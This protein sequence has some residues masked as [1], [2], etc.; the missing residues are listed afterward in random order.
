MCLRSLNRL[1][2]TTGICVKI[3]RKTDKPD[4]F[5]NQWAMFSKDGSGGAGGAGAG[6]RRSVKK[7]NRSGVVYKIDR[8]YRVKHSR[9]A[10]S[11]HM[12]LPYLALVHCYKSLGGAE[13]DC[14]QRV[15]AGDHVYIICKYAG[16]Q[17]QD[18]D[19][20][21]AKYVTPLFALTHKQA[22]EFK[23]VIR[24]H[25]FKKAVQLVNCVKGI[26]KGE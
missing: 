4:E 14:G 22:Q 21:T 20:L 8:T 3:V 17:Y 9:M 23:E 16:G 13:Q 18:T 24:E 5:R 19:S 12:S 26:F 11:E 25:G 15:K 2:Q 7:Y 6:T 10:R 1:E